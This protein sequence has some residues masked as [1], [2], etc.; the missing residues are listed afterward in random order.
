MRLFISKKQQSINCIK[1]LNKLQKIKI[2]LKYVRDAAKTRWKIV[3][4]IQ[5]NKH[6]TETDIHS[7]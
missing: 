5:K 7:T 4:K 3:K 6:R 1:V 2:Y